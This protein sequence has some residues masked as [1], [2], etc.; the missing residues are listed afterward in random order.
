MIGKM[1]VVRYDVITIEHGRPQPRQSFNAVDAAANLIA[2]KHIA[3]HIVKCRTNALTATVNKQRQDGL[4]KR[5]NKIL[6]KKRF[7]GEPWQP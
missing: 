1:N 4:A 6:A 5:V 7:T 3:G 2:Q